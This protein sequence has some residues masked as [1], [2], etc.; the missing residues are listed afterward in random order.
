ML[1]SQQL[2]I[3][4]LAINGKKINLINRIHIYCICHVNNLAY[5]DFVFILQLFAQKLFFYANILKQI[6]VMLLRIFGETH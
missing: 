1:V 4:Y 6:F 2:L 5:L 3:H